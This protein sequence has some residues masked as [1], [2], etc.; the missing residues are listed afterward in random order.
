[1]SY[2]CTNQY[3]LQW[4]REVYRTYLRATV[5]NN[6]DMTTDVRGV[7]GE[8][9]TPGRLGDFYNHS[10]RV[11]V[12]FVHLKCDYHY[13]GL[14]FVE[15]MVQSLGSTPQTRSNQRLRQRCH[16]Q[17]KSCE[18]QNCCTHHVPRLH[19]R[20]N[21]RKLASTQTPTAQEGDVLYWGFHC[22]GN[23]CSTGFIDSVLT[24]RVDRSDLPPLDSNKQALR[25]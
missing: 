3:Y 24:S 16:G 21:T 23:P 14:W 1:M 8:S 5:D 20:P 17:G 25:T 22:T 4:P 12:H 15:H 18:C 7:R 10:E 2:Q 19:P 13:C 11:H 9:Y 6:T